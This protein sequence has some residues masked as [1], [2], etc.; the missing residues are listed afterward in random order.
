MNKKDKKDKKA[1]LNDPNVRGFIDWLNLEGPN[2]PIH[3]QVKKSRFVPVSI[4]QKFTGIEKAINYYCWKSAGMVKGDWHDCSAT[5]SRLSKSLK[6]TLAN[7]DDHQTLEACKDILSWGGNRSWKRGAWPF[8][9]RIHGI[10]SYLQ[11]CKSTLDLSVADL[12]DLGKVQHLNS[13][14][15]KVHALASDDGLPIYDSRVAAAIA[16]LVELW[17]RAKGLWQTPLPQLLVFPSVYGGRSVDDAFV[18]AKSPGVLTGNQNQATQ[19]ASAK[20]RLGWIMQEL[21]SR[22]SW[23][24]EAIPGTKNVPLKFRMHAAEASLFML[25]YDVSCLHSLPVP[26]ASRG[27]GATSS[28]TTTPLSG[29]GS[30]IRYSGTSSTGF[31][32][33]WGSSSFKISPGLLSSIITEFSGQKLIPL[34][35]SRTSPSAESFGEWLDLESAAHSGMASAIAAVLVNEGYASSVKAI[36][37]KSIYLSFK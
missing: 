5:L 36:K 17:R 15:T 33:K 22:N 23:F 26:A 3:L 19:W 10:S 32:G 6:N 8:L 7:G 24:A 21:L 9:E 28:K 12:E 30:E 25:G 16:V 1:F 2:L 34:G 27:S 37:G 20:V 14:L 4:D 31:T 11:T 35:A 29:G 13:M 18:D